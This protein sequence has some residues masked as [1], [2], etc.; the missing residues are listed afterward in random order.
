MKRYIPKFESGFSLAEMLISMTIAMVIAVAL[1]PVVGMKKVRVPINNMNHGIAECYYDTSGKL[2]YF[3]ATSDREVQPHDIVIEEGDTCT[4]KAPRAHYFE[5][6]TVGAGGNGSEVEPALY[7]KNSTQDTQ[8][9]GYININENFQN[10][11]AKADDRSFGLANKIRLAL[12]N[13]AEQSPNEVV[14]Q[15]S[16][17]SPLGKSGASVCTP[18]VLGNGVQDQNS[19]GNCPQLCPENDSAAGRIGSCPGPG[20]RADGGFW[21]DLA[22]ARDEIKSAGNCWVY[23]H[24]RGSDS[25]AGRQSPDDSP[26]TIPINST[27]KISIVQN[28]TKAMVSVVNT[29]KQNNNSITYS[30]ELGHSADGVKPTLKNDPTSGFHKY[31]VPIAL[32]PDPSCTQNNLPEACNLLPVDKHYKNVAPAGGKEN[33]VNSGCSENTSP[34]TMGKV[35]YKENAYKWNYVKGK[36]YTKQ[37]D[38]GTRGDINSMV[39]ENMTGN[40]TMHPARSNVVVDGEPEDANKSYILFGTDKKALLSKSGANG[41]YFIHHELS[42][43]KSD[44]P[45]IKNVYDRVNP[46]NRDDEKYAAMLAK[47]NGAGFKGGL[48][49]CQDDLCPGFAGWSPYIYLPELSSDYNLTLTNLQTGSSYTEYGEGYT[50]SNVQATCRDGSQPESPKSLDDKMIKIG[51]CRGGRSEANPGAVIIIW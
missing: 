33:D 51:I 1:V 29:N 39:Y 23:L 7:K 4:F 36:Y 27:S 21:Y 24:G 9:S 49:D 13:W 45:I 41:K 40:F 42:I 11:I 46:Q 10:D 35:E 22:S 44:L 25:Q 37:Y 43:N 5:V 30:V 17:R 26:I 12:D 19:W 34:A 48:F 38:A 14:A 8:D 2:H 15:Y 28:Y 6:I 31:V 16:L 18:Y 3:Y 32:N 50:P 20:K 47:I